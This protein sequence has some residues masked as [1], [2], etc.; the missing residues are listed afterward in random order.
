MFSFAFLDMARRFF[1]FNKAT[2][3]FE[4]S[5]KEETGQWVLKEFDSLSEFY[6]AVGKDLHGCDLLDYDFNGVDISQFDL[7]GA[8]VTSDF[9]KANGT[10]DASFFDSVISLLP[11]GKSNE[12]AI[13][14]DY[15]KALVDPSRT[16]DSF[17]IHSILYITDIHLDQKIRAR[18]ID[19]CNEFEVRRYLDTII[20]NFKQDS[21]EYSC[22]DPYVLIG[23]DVSSNINISRMFFE[24]L[25]HVFS[26]QNIIY[27]LGNHELWATHNSGRTTY[28]QVVKE[29][30]QMAR[31]LNIT[32]LENELLIV[33]SGR[34]VYSCKNVLKA[35]NEDV[36]EEADKASLIV[37]GGIGFAPNNMSY[38]ASKGQYGRT[39]RDLEEERKLSAE[40]ELFYLKLRSSISHMNVIILSHMPLCDW[41]DTDYCARWY[42][43]SGHNHQNY[44]E[45]NEHRNVF[46][47]NQIGYADRPIHLKKFDYFR[48]YDLFFCYKDG[49]YEIT[50]QQY[51]DFY[52]NLG[53]F[54]QYNR[55]SNLWMLKRSGYYMFFLKNEMGQLFLM[56][57]GA[58]NCLECSDLQ[59]YYDLIPSFASKTDAVFSKYNGAIKDISKVVK[60]IGGSGKIHGCIV[61]IDFFNHIYLNPNDGSITPYYAT[62]IVNKLVYP[63]VHSLLQAQRSDLL[64]GYYA[65]EDSEDDETNYYPIL[66]DDRNDKPIK[67]VDTDIYEYSRKIMKFQYLTENHIIRTWDSRLVDG[68]ISIL[69]CLYL[70]SGGKRA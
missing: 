65:Q 18:F 40:F 50:P 7:D 63:S 22:Y 6:E 20:D 14:P 58:I 45:I 70:L 11:E 60:A 30:H 38:N 67:Y 55:A 19:S 33:K 27:I 26:P 66:F 46:A 43:I 10:Y 44:L 57:G 29:Y 69:D 16:V 68:S 8:K 37:L 15:Q 28:K 51:R 1:G 32:L 34:Q 13:V 12:S 36:I 61:D 59:Y 62:D 3:K 47:D 35:T 24:E 41:S 2:K 21:R 5:V 25:S 48:A 17:F 39:I 31:E 56:N 54:M 42:Y 4:A 9:Q 53:L 49:I 23:G 64:P 52:R